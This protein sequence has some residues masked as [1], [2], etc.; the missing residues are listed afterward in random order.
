MKTFFECTLIVALAGLGI[1]AVTEVGS[2]VHN[3]VAWPTA[4][5][6]VLSV[7]SGAYGHAQH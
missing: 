2:L 5:A 1:S 6:I 3:W 4:I 7:I